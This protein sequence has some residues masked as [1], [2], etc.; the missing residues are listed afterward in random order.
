MIETP[1]S[2]SPKLDWTR[3]TADH[4][5][6]TPEEEIAYAAVAGRLLASAE[7]LCQQASELEVP[8]SPEAVEILFML[9]AE[10]IFDLL[11]VSAVDVAPYIV[12]VP[13]LGKDKIAAYYQDKESGHHFILF[14]SEKI[15]AAALILEKVLANPDADTPLASDE[16][17]E[18]IYAIAHEVGHLRQEEKL[19]YFS[20]RE[21]QA[22]NLPGWEQSQEN[23]TKYNTDLAE[24]NAHAVAI[25]YVLAKKQAKQLSHIWQLLDF[26]R[27]VG[28]HLETQGRYRKLSDIFKAKKLVDLRDQ[29]PDYETAQKYQRRAE[30]LLTHIQSMNQR[31]DQA[32]QH[33]GSTP[34]PEPAT[35]A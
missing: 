12:P 6:Y 27:V 26:S 35:T 10:V 13:N 30:I 21:A 22:H 19:A 2:T 33:L 24:S 25:R 29:A 3:V 14:S 17:A 4:H 23:L 11:S 32:H 15:A 34:P 28:K 7:V 31:L 20:D 1:P 16:L 18:T 9:L 5:Q 8:V